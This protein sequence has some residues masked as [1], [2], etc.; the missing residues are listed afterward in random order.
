MCNFNWYKLAQNSKKNTCNF[1]EAYNVC[2]VNKN[3][4]NLNE[5]CS[6]FN[7][8]SSF[9]MWRLN[10]NGLFYKSLGHKL[11]KKTLA[12]SV[13]HVVIWMFAQQIKMVCSTNVQFNFNSINAAIR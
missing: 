5:M 13:R 7:E 9:I 1:S 3:V 11:A 12:I 2:I 4:C 10:K 8:K 6:E